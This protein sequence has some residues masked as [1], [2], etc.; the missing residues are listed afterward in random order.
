MK[1]IKIKPRAKV[2]KEQEETLLIEPDFHN[3]DY[4]RIHKSLIDDLI[5]THD[6]ITE[7]RGSEINNPETWCEERGFFA[8]KNLLVKI[9]AI[10]QAAK[11]KFGS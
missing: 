6:L 1:R 3:P 9:N 11:G 7:E 8:L 4:Y 5:R 10:Q 2:Y